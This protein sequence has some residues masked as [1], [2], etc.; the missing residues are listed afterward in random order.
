MSEAVALG[1]PLAL[2]VAL[3]FGMW[4]GSVI[5][6]EMDS[7]SQ[8]ADKQPAWWRSAVIMAEARKKAAKEHPD[9]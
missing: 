8:V 5:Q 1:M 3:A 2:V 6:C 4:R 9:A 7:D